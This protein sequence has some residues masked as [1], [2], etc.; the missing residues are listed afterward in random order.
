MYKLGDFMKK[1]MIVLIALIAIGV[2]ISAVS[3]E[4][5]NFSFGSESNT[6]GGD[7]TI[8]NDKLTIQGVEFKIPNGF[9]ENETGRLLANQT[10]A[11]GEP[12]K[13]SLTELTKD[14]TTIIV[15]TFFADDG[16][17]E[18]LTGDNSKTIAGHKGFLTQNEDNAIFD[19]IV[20]GK[21]VE[22]KA[23]TE[24]DI[25]SVIK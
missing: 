21:I 18:N 1:I 24:A 4:G 23:P 11:F 8:E 10:E 2:S 5:F 3:A 12:C 15:K 6:D 22:I 13:V 9:K 20:D 25:E 19:Y 14:N 17:F 16:K 7:I